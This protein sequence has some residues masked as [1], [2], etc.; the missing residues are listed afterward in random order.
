MYHEV[1]CILNFESVAHGRMK[2]LTGMLGLIKEI[3]A[4]ANK[5]K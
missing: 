4:A 2:D 1:L 5:S 3:F